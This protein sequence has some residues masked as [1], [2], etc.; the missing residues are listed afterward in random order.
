MGLWSCRAPVLVA[1]FL[2]RKRSFYYLTAIIVITLINNS[3]KTWYSEPRPY[4]LNP[5]GA[6][7][8]SYSFGNPSGHSMNG[9]GLPLLY[10]LDLYHST[11]RKCFLGLFLSIAGGLGIA[12]GYSRVFLGVHSLNQVVYGSLIG[13]WIA[14][15]F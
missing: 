10:C 1:F 15:T 3:M 14:V 12:I 9:I 13:I 8:C 2:D 6:L 5:V 4:W 7:K 11:N